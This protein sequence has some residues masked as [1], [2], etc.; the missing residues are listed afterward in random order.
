VVTRPPVERAASAS[1]I[2]ENA[3]DVP[4][5]SIR[6]APIALTRIQSRRPVSP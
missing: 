2:V 1:Y 4:T 3:L 6:V 5:S